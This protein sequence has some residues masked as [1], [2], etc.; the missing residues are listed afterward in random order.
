MAKSKS[1]LTE[2][3]WS[4]IGDRYLRGE[5]ARALAREIGVT[6][7]AIRK[8]FGTQVVRIK[9][10]V[11]QTL[12]AEREFC[13]LDYSTQVRAKNYL[14]ELRLASMELASAALNGAKTAKHLS[15]I[16]K[17]KAVKITEDVDKEEL[18][19]INGL[20]TVA[21]SAAKTAVDLIKAVKPADHEEDKPQEADPMESLMSSIHAN[22]KGLPKNGKHRQVA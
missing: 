12:E 20:T 21:N 17:K 8:R 13:E 22:N 9:K 11:N 19:L 3:Q 5:G 2:K 4:E 1:K 16:A 14:D 10:I 6:E 7:G 15:G 18:A